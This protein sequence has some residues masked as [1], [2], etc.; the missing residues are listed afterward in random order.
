MSMLANLIG[1]S[2]QLNVSNKRLKQF[3]AADEIDA[4]MVRRLDD[5]KTKPAAEISDA[6]FTWDM[7]VS[8]TRLETFLT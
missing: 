8:T 7:Q 2:V 6:A 4:S 5:E 3:L 1:Q